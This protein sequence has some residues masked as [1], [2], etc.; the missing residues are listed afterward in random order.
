MTNSYKKQ[1]SLAVLSVV[2]ATAMIASVIA[3]SDSAFASR[4][5]HGKGH[6]NGI[7]S[8]DDNENSA[9]QSIDQSC[10]QNQ[11]SSVVTAGAISP[12]FGSGNNFAGCFNI[13]GGGN[14]ASQEQ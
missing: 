13:N 5:G 6:F 8:Q 4:N 9:V 12:V 2:F 7:G 14:A 11:K 1:I 10:S 3:T